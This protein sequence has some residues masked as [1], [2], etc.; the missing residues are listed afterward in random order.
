MKYEVDEIDS[1]M[2]WTDSKTRVPEISLPFPFDLL[3]KKEKKE[4]SWQPITIKIPERR[5]SPFFSVYI[6]SLTLRMYSLLGYEK[7]WIQNFSVYAD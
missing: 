7:I 2:M 4:M 5:V 6:L 3:K 1:Q